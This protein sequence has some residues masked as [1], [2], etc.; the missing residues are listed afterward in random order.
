[1]RPPLGLH[2]RGGGP[3]TLGSLASQLAVF[4]LHPARRAEA[5]VRHVR[6]FQHNVDVS[7]IVVAH[8]RS[9]ILCL[10]AAR[11]PAMNGGVC[12]RSNSLGDCSWKRCATRLDQ[13]VLRGWLHAPLFDPQDARSYFVSA[14]ASGSDQPRMHA[15][16]ECM[17]ARSGN[18]DAARECGCKS[19]IAKARADSPRHARLSLL[20]T[21]SFSGRSNVGKS[22]LLNA[23]CRQH[24]LART[25][26]VP[27]SVVSRYHLAREPPSH[28]C[29]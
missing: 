15:C 24:G 20:H 12:R 18:D 25:S 19:C 6:V 23:V 16:R 28:P 26:K 11:R 21:H 10:V 4:G 27:S 3:F 29:P 2:L 14:S 8:A 5:S 13:G 1:M 7:T 17:F 22:S 9:N